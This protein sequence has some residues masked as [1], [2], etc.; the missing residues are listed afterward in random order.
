MFGF[1]YIKT[2]FTIFRTFPQQRVGFSLVF[3]KPETSRTMQSTHHQ[4]LQVRHIIMPL[5][6]HGTAH[7]GS[8]Q[9]DEPPN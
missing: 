4:S 3:L 6:A 9:V 7:T 5:P 1:D 2:F 8:R